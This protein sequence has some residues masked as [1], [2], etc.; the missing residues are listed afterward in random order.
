MLM[1]A[2]VVDPGPLRLVGA[3]MWPGSMQCGWYLCST[4]RNNR[5]RA[6]V[7]T[8]YGGQDPLPGVQVEWRWGIVT[9]KSRHGLKLPPRIVCLS[10]ATHVLAV[11]EGWDP[12]DQR[13]LLRLVRRASS[14]VAIC[15]VQARK[16]GSLHLAR[17]TEG[18]AKIEGE[19]VRV[20]LSGG[21]TTLWAYCLRKTA[22]SPATDPARASVLNQSAWISHEEIQTR[23]MKG[24]CVVLGARHNL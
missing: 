19:P 5:Y 20:S 16:S 22:V 1:L 3:E 13:E 21:G 2:A 15:V 18:W 6:G 10:G 7:M 23:A 24:R 12:R 17:I 14:V 11:W 9:P 4:G 8:K